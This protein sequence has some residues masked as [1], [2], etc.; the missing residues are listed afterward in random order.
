MPT[1]PRGPLQPPSTQ[2]GLA[3]GAAY[4]HD[5]LAPVSGV[6]LLPPPD[7][8]PGGTPAVSCHS[9]GRRVLAETSVEGRGCSRRTRAALRPGPGA[10]GR[11]PFRRPELLLRALLGPPGAW[12]DRLDPAGVVLLC[13]PEP[14]TYAEWVLSLGHQLSTSGDVALSLFLGRG[15]AQPRV[16]PRQRSPPGKCPRRGARGSSGLGAQTPWR[17]PGSP[18]T[19]GVAPAAGS[20]RSEVSV[21][22]IVPRS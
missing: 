12:R 19:P 17:Q 11:R 16:T 13:P 2:T 20:L 5:P 4:T 21:E 6:P 8:F 15:H 18:S 1:R 3:V 14:G 9:P 22:T 7:R 10:P